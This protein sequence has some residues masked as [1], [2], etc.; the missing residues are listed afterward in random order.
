MWRAHD[1]ARRMDGPPRRRDLNVAALCCDDRRDAVAAVPAIGRGTC[2][3]QNVAVT[4]FRSSCR[5]HKRR[6]W[7]ALHMEAAA[8]R[9]VPF[10][11]WE[12][13][14]AERE[15]AGRH[16]IGSEIQRQLSREI[17]P[18]L[19][20]AELTHEAV[21]KDGTRKLLMTMLA[22]GAQV[23]AVLIP[24]LPEGGRRAQNARAHTT[25]CISSQ[26][27]C[28]MACAFCATGR[29][30]LVR[31]LSAD[32]IL[33]QAWL[34]R[35]VVVRSGMPS[36]T[37]VVFMGMGE[38]TDNMDAV[39]A[40][41]ASLSDPE[42]FGMAR[43]KLLVSTVAPSPQAF[44]NVLCCSPDGSGGGGE[45]IAPPS[46]AW[47]LHAA[48]ESLRKLL[49]P[50]ATFSPEILRDG[51]CGALGSQ[52]DRR[53]RRVLIECTLIAGINDRP[54]DADA[55]AAFLAPVVDACRDERRNS[56]RT[57]VLVNLI[58]YNPS[59]ARPI[60]ERDGA[61]PEGKPRSFDPSLPGARLPHHSMFRR[62]DRAAV[63]AFQARLRERGLWV[64]IRAAR[65]DDEAS[66]CGQLATKALARHEATRSKMRATAAA[67]GGSTSRPEWETLAASGADVAPLQ[68]CSACEGVGLVP[69]RKKRAAT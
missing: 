36:L 28:R 40:A 45:F 17:M 31:N 60:D 57:G 30:G 41:V 8:A 68:C 27:G 10:D 56:T 48:D 61:S 34:A 11:E 64:S 21:A 47:S 44:S 69:S 5:L 25:L 33:V 58:P 54:S 42:R 14:D 38:P 1:S 51:L 26:V 52:P 4:A 20:V 66:A 3:A 46:L 6:T 53:R 7:R 59:A 22:D 39:R 18:L 37:S 43:S 19:G 9:V 15:T 2:E 35:R 23:E 32:E 63:E 29:M 65:G 55:L 49:V 24:P 13:D 12:H 16:R 67:K 62:P 50:T